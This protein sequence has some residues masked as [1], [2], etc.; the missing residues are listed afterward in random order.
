VPDGV[1]TPVLLTRCDNAGDC[2][3][4]AGDH[5]IRRGMSTS[6]LVPLKMPIM[7]IRTTRQIMTGHNDIWNKTMDGFLV[8]FL[9]TVV[10]RPEVIPSID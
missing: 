9:L 5:F 2:A 6:G 8:Q 10:A 7:N 1:S 4:V 3:N